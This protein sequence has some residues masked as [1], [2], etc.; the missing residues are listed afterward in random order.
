MLANSKKRS[1][2]EAIKKKL[3]LILLSSN[4]KSVVGNNTF[5]AYEIYTIGGLILLKKLDQ[6][7]STIQLSAY[8]KIINKAHYDSIYKDKLLGIGAEQYQTD[9][10]INKDIEHVFNTIYG[11]ISES[12][13]LIQ[14]SDTEH[15]DKDGDIAFKTIHKKR[16]MLKLHG[17]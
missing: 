9:K 14:T 4:I 2:E 16:I 15:L 1:K 10:K 7:K 11:I 17:K 13:D 12:F 8:N 5:G 6:Y 3:A